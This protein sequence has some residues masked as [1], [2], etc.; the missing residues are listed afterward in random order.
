[1]KI[2]KARITPGFGNNG[3]ITLYHTGGVLVKV[4]EDKM[5]AE[6]SLMDNRKMYV[7]KDGRLI[8]HELPEYGET[9]VVTIGGK[10]DRL[11]TTVKKKV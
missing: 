1:M 10:V 8:E 7:V 11:E 6:I 4:K 9:V 2:K 3:S 5:R